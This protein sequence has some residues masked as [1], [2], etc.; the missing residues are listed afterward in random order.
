MKALKSY[1]DNNGRLAIPAKIRKKL[2][3]NIGDEV[4]LKYSDSE[5]I[6]STFHYNIE[7]ARNILSKYKH[8]NLQEELQ[9]MRKE[10]ANKAKI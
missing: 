8:L 10:D 4:A 3:L 9:L 7:N 2:H 1:I 6:V 5:L